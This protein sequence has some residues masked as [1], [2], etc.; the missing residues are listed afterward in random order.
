MSET[1]VVCTRCGGVN[2]LP[3]ARPAEGAKCGKCGARLFADHPD[4]VDGANL[5]RQ[6]AKGTIP[7][8]VDVWAP[9]C[10]PC[11]M[12]TPAFEAASQRFG[13]RVR[14]V[15]LNSETEQAAA[16]R[17]TIRSIPTMIL[18]LGGR[19]IGRSSG[20]MTTGQ[21]VEW[22]SARLPAAAA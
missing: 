4:D 7:V 12:M 16:A 2:R 20:A 10:G 8:L 18:F 13:P 15:K 17:L 1:R 14:A 9:W 3:P 5:D 21:I 6:I 19:E 11:R 22:V